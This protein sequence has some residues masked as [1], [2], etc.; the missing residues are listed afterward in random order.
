MSQRL[1]ARVRC[2]E[3]SCLFHPWDQ[4][5]ICCSRSCGAKRTWKVAAPKH[6]KANKIPEYF[7]WKGMNQRCNCPSTKN[8]KNY[9]GRGIRV[10][11]SWKSFE[12][13]F[14]DMGPRPSKE[15]SIHREN[16]DG[17]YSPTN[18]RW[19]TRK[20]QQRN[21]RVNRFLT[22]DGERKT[23]VEW[24]EFLGVNPDRLHCRLTRG[25]STARTLTQPI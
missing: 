12:N 16:N 25:W 13:F 5:G 14:E 20:E 21:T 19:A 10:C 24:A 22:F 18:C 7:V 3:C 15:H 4:D 17:D 23:V 1:K 11:A 6:G 9:G 8:F 2:I